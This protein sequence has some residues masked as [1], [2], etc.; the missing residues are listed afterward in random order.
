MDK[1]WYEQKKEEALHDIGVA[2]QLTCKLIEQD[3]HFQSVDKK[4]LIEKVRTCHDATADDFQWLIYG[5]RCVNQN[6]EGFRFDNTKYV[7]QKLGFEVIRSCKSMLNAIE[8][9]LDSEWVDIEGDIVITDPCYTTD[10]WCEGFNLDSLPLCRDTIYGDW[11]CT[12]F[13]KKTE[14]P[15]GQF[16]ADA[17]MV[18]VDTLE[19]ILKRKPDFIDEY[20]EWCRTIIKNFKGKVRF[21]IVCLDEVRDKTKFD[22]WNYEVRVEGEGVNTETGK[23]IQFITAQTGL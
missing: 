9:L 6:N 13:D 20:G 22:T 16:C 19:N 8:R 1:Q 4:Y 10:K 11:S 2:I 12:T 23:E 14:K 21:K 7:D 17:G 18:C 3:N 15:I 5:I